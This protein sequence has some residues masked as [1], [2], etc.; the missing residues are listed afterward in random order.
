MI[1]L[2]GGTDAFVRRPFLDSGFW[3][4]LLGGVL[5]LVMVLAATL[6]LVEPVHV[7]AELYQSDFALV[8]LSAGSS[9]ALVAAGAAL[10]LAGAWVAVARHLERLQPA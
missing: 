5:A 8:G 3:F 6:L 9:A 10:G 7:L 2:V 4:G 1:R